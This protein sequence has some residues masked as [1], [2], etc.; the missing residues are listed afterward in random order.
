MVKIP[1]QFKVLN[2]VSKSNEIIG[3]FWQALN[4]IDL[5][6]LVLHQ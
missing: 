1:A 6:L 4:T 2:G 3:V 5:E